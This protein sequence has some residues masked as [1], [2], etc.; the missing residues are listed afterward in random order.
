M[1]F[2]DRCGSVLDRETAMKLKQADELAQVLQEIIRQ[3]PELVD[4]RILEEKGLKAKIRQVAE[5]G[6]GAAVG[7]NRLLSVG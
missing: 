6:Q 4:H 7:D 1:R 5:F 3:V 2:C